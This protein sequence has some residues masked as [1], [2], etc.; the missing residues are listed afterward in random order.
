RARVAVVKNDLDNETSDL[1]VM[2][3]AGGKTT[4]L[5]TSKKTEFVQAPVW[6]PDGKQLAYVQIR[7]GVEGVYRRL[8]DG[9]GA[10]E[11]VYKNTSAFLGLSDWSLDGR[12]LS[13][14]NS[15]LSGGALFILPLTGG[16]AREPREV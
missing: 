4:R 13:F 11:L 5:T 10:E 8:A 12:Y 9:T 7:D 1:F 14:S 3:I 15:D 6:S 16:A 2:E